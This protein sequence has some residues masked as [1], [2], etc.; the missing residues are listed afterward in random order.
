[1][2]LEELTQKQLDILISMSEQ[3]QVFAAIVANTL[4]ADATSPDSIE[5]KQRAMKVIKKSFEFGIRVKDDIE[6]DIL[7]KMRDCC[8]DSIM[9]SLFEFE[10]IE[11]TEETK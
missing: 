6:L 1:M 8:L 9:N 11:E 2:K 10:E 5:I 4:C 7:K 3:R